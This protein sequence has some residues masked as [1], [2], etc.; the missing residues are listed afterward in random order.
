MPKK[1]EQ[2]FAVLLMVLFII[3]SLLTVLLGYSALAAQETSNDLGRDQVVYLN[4]AKSSITAWYAQNAESIDATGSSL[5]TAQQI[6]SGANVIKKY[7]VQVAASDRIVD[8]NIDYRII[9]LWIDSGIQ[10]SSFNVT[11]GVL[12]PGSNTRYVTINGFPV[13]TEKSVQSINIMNNLATLLEQRFDDKA[14]ANGGGNSYINYFRPADGSCTANG[15]DSPCTDTYPWEDATTIDLDTALGIPGS[16]LVNAWGV[17]VQV[18]NAG[19]CDAP[20]TTTP[21]VCPA[22]ETANPPSG[23]TYC[24]ANV[25]A[26]PYSMIIRSASPWGYEVSVTATQ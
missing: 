3:G 18:C 10:H 9:A 14:A 1:S 8:G 25:T 23:P 22:G 19:D 7:N 20:I 5:P 15:D 6:L 21:F 26:P 11:T 24:G 16:T 12:T 2:G 4:T 17:P 13:E